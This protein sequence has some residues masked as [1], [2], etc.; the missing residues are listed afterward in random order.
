MTSTSKWL[1]LVGCLLVGLVG[2]SSD[3]T[4]PTPTTTQGGSGGT[5]A[6]GGGGTGGG[7]GGGT[8]GSVP[9]CQ[10]TDVPC[11]DQIIQEMNLQDDLAPGLIDNQP[12]GD[13]WN[14]HVDATA[15]GAFASDPDSYVYGVFTETG[16][17]KVEM[18]DED[19][20][21]SMDWDIAFRRYVIR[22]NSGH[23]GPACVMAGRVAGTADYDAI[24]AVPDGVIYNSDEY[25][26]ENCTL[27]PDGSG[28]PNS[29]ATALSSYWTYP[30]C[31]QMSYNVFLVELA[32]GSHLKLMVTNYYEEPGQQQCQ[33][34]DASPSSG[35]AHIRF[36]WAFLP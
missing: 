2:C 18:S 32:D 26:T 20:I 21:D 6:T 4:E 1:G 36:R 9:A 33:D 7:V 8:G 28:L 14:T 17:T 27:M 11:S 25:F 3:E 35:S 22:I 30:G 13:G 24:A 29:P 10:P 5:G 16:L 19:S 31:V 23:S 34:T 15:G 12:D